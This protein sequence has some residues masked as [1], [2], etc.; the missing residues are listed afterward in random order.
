MLILRECFIS[1]LW[2]VVFIF[3]TYVVLLTLHVL[4]QPW[5]PLYCIGVRRLYLAC[6]L[7]SN[8]F[9]SV[10]LSKLKRL[11]MI[12]ELKAAY[13]LYKVIYSYI[14]NFGCRLLGYR[15]VL[16]LFVICLVL[17]F[18]SLVWFCFPLIWYCY[19]LVKRFFYKMTNNAQ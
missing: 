16:S 9:S 11:F 2:F 18:L 8:E 12:N 3:T 7:A 10:V 6:L 13:C 17:L 15:L 1:I 4:S 19:I 14:W 5:L